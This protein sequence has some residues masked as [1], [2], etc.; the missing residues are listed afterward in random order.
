MLPAEF[1]KHVCSM[2]YGDGD[3][4]MVSKIELIF[5]RKGRHWHLQINAMVEKSTVDK[6]TEPQAPQ[7][8]NSLPLLITI[9]FS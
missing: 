1:Q 7:L 5:G 8:I 6:N 3:L 2:C 4:N 9:L